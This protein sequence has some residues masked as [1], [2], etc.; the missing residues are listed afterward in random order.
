MTA[1]LSLTDYP[2]LSEKTY[3]VIRDQIVTGIL[4]PGSQLLVVDLAKRLGVSRTPVKDA[5]NR[6]AAEGLVQHLRRKGYL[7]PRLSAGDVAD[8]VDARAVVEIGA[9][10]R[11]IKSIGVADLANL[12]RL[13]DEM[14][15]LIDQMGNC[16]DYA[17]FSR[18]DCEFHLATVAASKNPR[19]VEIYETLNLYSY[20]VKTHYSGAQ[21]EPRWARDVME[22]H[23]AIIQGFESRDWT[24]LRAAISSHVY[25]G[26]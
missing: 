17:E 13:F 10:E 20:L 21:A 5:L 1:T 25:Y 22:E 2:D 14:E 19:L 15:T 24:V 26:F 7:V 16:L 23:R 11:A 8:L 9:A 4:S 3:L 6:L 12:H 18:K